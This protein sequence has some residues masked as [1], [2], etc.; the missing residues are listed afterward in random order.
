MRLQPLTNTNIK[1]ANSTINKTKTGYMQKINFSSQD[2]LELTSKKDTKLSLVDAICDFENAGIK[3]KVLED[4]TLSIS[5]YAPDKTFIKNL[6]HK[7][8]DLFEHV[9][10]I[11]TYADFTFS[12]LKSTQA[13]KKIG[14]SVIFSFSKI[15]KTPNLEYIGKDAYYNN[16][17]I[18]DC[19]GVTILRDAHF[20]NSKVENPYSA[21]VGRNMLID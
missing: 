15:E 4:G 17:K 7:E 9:S 1:S 2:T 8:E 12:K 18:K 21:T 3:T 10:E 13:L 11:E 14:K 20:E 6:K 19:N 5:D 16:S